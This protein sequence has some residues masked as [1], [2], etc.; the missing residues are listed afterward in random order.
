[1]TAPHLPRDEDTSTMSCVEQLSLP[2]ASRF[3]VRRLGPCPFPSPQHNGDQH[4]VSD[5]DAVLATAS[6]NDVQRLQSRGQ[7]LPAFELAGPRERLHFRPDTIAAGIVTCGG[8][9]PGMNNVIRAIVLT[10]HHAYGMPT[11]YG[12][13]YGF[14]GLGTD[15]HEPL[16]LTPEVVDGIHEY[17]G[18]L[19]GSSRGPQEPSTMV[20][21]LESLGIRVLFAVGGDGTL[22]G[23]EKIAAEIGRRGLDIAV[24]G[25]P[26]TIDNDIQWIERSFAT[27]VEEAVR[28][29]DAAHNE[30]RGVWNGVG[31]VKLMGR[32]SG[33][34]AA[35][36][37]LA[38]SVVNFCLVPETGLELTG[39]DGFLDAL[40][41]R[42]H[43]RHHA[44]V[45]VAE[46]TGQD[47]VA[48]REPGRDR[49]GNAHLADIGAFLAARISQHFVDIGMD[50]TVKYLDPSYAIRSLQ[51]NAIDAE[52]CFALGQNAVH[53]AM[54]GRTNT[55][56]GYW[57]QSFTHVPIELAVG[58]PRR[59]DPA[60][61]EWQR[62]L[63][64]TGQRSAARPVSGQRRTSES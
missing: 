19:L 36:A 23:V 9:C 37:T 43:D 52:F 63:Q 53:A 59:L 18:T 17:G 12:F 60:G 21:R 28:V 57:N 31:L 40:G 58:Q 44:V 6:R 2:D 14:A 47:L 35:H 13:R 46:G 1:M 24:I 49:S 27:A 51:A 41:Q 15:L 50:G 48:C 56:I 39:P 3:D 61:Q 11:I 29:I 64:T 45:V 22:R 55:M 34:I 62:V 54:A 42:L 16:R 5:E 7:R 25:I 26:K 8:L 10:L 38:S 33:F 30:A 20:D 4:F 32:N